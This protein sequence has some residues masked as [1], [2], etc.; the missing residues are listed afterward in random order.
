MSDSD[1]SYFYLSRYNT[2]DVVFFSSL[3]FSRHAHCQKMGKSK[4]LSLCEQINQRA[5]Q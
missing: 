1:L 5:K 2:L 3:A 4:N